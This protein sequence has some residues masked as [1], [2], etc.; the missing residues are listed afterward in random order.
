L[1][2]DSVP[3]KLVIA[4]KMPALPGNRAFCT[5]I[6]IESKVNGMSIQRPDIDKINLAG[7]NIRLNSCSNRC[8]FCCPEGSYKSIDNEELK[9]TEIN[10]FNQVE[11]LKKRGFRVIEITGDDP[12]EY[13]EIPQFINWLKNDMNFLRV[14]LATHGRNLRDGNL[15]KRLKEAGLD[16]L[17]IPVYGSTGAIHD[18][19]T[20]EQGSFNETIKGINNVKEVAP[21]MGI[22]VTTLIM[23]QNYMDIG[24]ILRLVS[25][26]ASLATI[27]L[28]CISDLKSSESFSISFKDMKPHLLKLTKDFL[29]IDCPFFILDIPYCVFGFYMLNIINNIEPPSVADNYSPP[30]KF[31]TGRNDLPSYRIKAKLDICIRCSL[32]NICNG[33]YKNHIEMYDLGYLE[34]LC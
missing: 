1:P 3:T 13:E 34:P 33:F 14:R 22:I 27:G 32:R 16:E 10:V 25:K 11:N 31:R 12:V 18:L 2:A 17:R 9:Q 6:I 23:K 30:E 21:E 20:Q 7:V 5:G 29:K 28:P 19:V 4:G 8:L 15:V 26:D 24:N